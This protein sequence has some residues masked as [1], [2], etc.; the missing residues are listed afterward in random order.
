MGWSC[1]HK[2]IEIIYYFKNYI[3]MKKIFTI[4]VLTIVLLL[5]GKTIFAGPIGPTATAPSGSG[6]SGSPYQISSLEN[7]YWLSASNVVVPSPDQATRWAAYYEQTNNIDATATSG[8]NPNV[9]G[10]FYGFSPIGNATTQFTG[11]YDGQNHTISNLYINRPA[12]D[13]IGLFGWLYTSGG[14]S[15]LGLTNIDVKGQ[16]GV[17]GLVGYIQSATISNVYTTGTVVGNYLYTSAMFGGLIGYNGSTCTITNSY[18]TANVTGINYGGGGLVG[19]NFGTI[20]SCYATG[21]VGGE[22]S[23][24]GGLVGENGGNISNSFAKGNVNGNV[25]DVNGEYFG[26]LVGRSRNTNITDCYATGSVTGHDMVGGL[27]GYVLATG[28]SSTITNSYSF[29]SV[30]GSTNV[31]GLIGYNSNGTITDSYWDTQTSGTAT[32]S[33]GTGKTTAQMKTLATF[34]SW[35]F[36]AG[37][38]IW[39]IKVPASGYISYPYLQGITYDTPEASPVVNP[40]PGLEKLPY[41]GGTGTSGD[42]YHITDWEQLHNISLN[43]SSYFV[44]D[45]DLDASS[46][47][48][49]T[50]AS[51]TANSNAGWLPLA[52]FSGNFNGNNH[53]IDGL[54]INRTGSDNIGLFGYSTG[55]I[56]NVGLINVTVSGHYRVGGLVG[57]NYTPGSISNVYTSGSVTSVTGDCGGL[58]GINSYASITNAYSTASVIGTVGY[59]GGLVGTN[60]G[61]TINKSYSAGSVPVIVSCSGG[62]VG[63]VGA[64]GTTND[65]FW[66]TQT[67]GQAS[68]A[69]GTG[70]TTYQMK[71]QVTFTAGGWDFATGTGVWTLVEASSGYR[72][73]PYFQSFTYDTPGDAP[74]AVNPIPGLLPIPVV[75][76]FA[77]LGTTGPTPYQT[78]KEAFDAINTGTHK[79]D[80]TITINV[81]TTETESAVLYH[82]GYSPVMFIGSSYD[83]VTIYPTVTGLSISGDLAAPLIDLNG[84]DNVTIDGRVNATGSTADLVITNTSASLTAGTSTIRFINDASNNTVKYNTLKGSSLDSGGGAIF[85][86]TTTGTTGN[87]NNTIDH[88]NITC[89]ADANRPVNA[90]Y[91]EGVYSEGTAAEDNSGNNLSNNNFY[92]FMR[93]G[94][95]SNGILLFTN[96]TAWTISGNSFYETSTFVPTAE[97]AAYYFIYIEN[98]GYNY[99]VTNNYI[100]GTA[101]LCGGTAF[102]KSSSPQYNSIFGGIYLSTNAGTASSIQ[103]NTISNISWTN[104]GTASWRGILTDGTGDVNIGT[105]TANTI[106]ASTGNASIYFTTSTTGATFYGIYLANTG[107]TVVHD[108]IIGAITTSNVATNATNL[109]G[110][111]KTGA[112]TTSI[113]NNL[114]GSATTSNSLYASW[115]ALNNAQIVCGI[116]SLGSGSVTISDNTISKLT[117]GTTATNAARTGSVNGIVATDGT[118]T[119]SGNT[120]R[121]LSIANANNTSNHTASVSGIAL[122][123]T[124]AAAQ[125]ITGNTIYNLSNTYTSFTGNVIGLYYNGSTTASTVSKNFIHSLSMTSPTTAA[126]IYGIK[127]QNGTTIWSNNII[128]IGS[129]LLTNIYGIYE[130]GDVGNNN[131]LYYNTIYISGDVGSAVSKS[132]ALFSA[133]STNTRNFRNNIFDNQRFMGAKSPDALYSNYA[134]WFDYAVSTNLT[135]GNNDYYVSVMGSSALG[136]FNSAVV[137]SVPL[138]TGLD[139]NSKSVDPVFA[140]AGGTLAANYLPSETS[141]IA[142]TGTGVTTDYDETTR[143]TSFPSMGAHEYSIEASTPTTQAYA[144]VFSAVGTTRM[145]IGWTNGNGANRVVFVKEGTG[146]ITN[147]TDNTTYTASADWTSKGT[148]LGTSGYYCVY[149]GSSNT[150]DLTGLSHSTSYYVQVFEYNGPALGEKYNTTT[151]T[152]NPK[153][154]ATLTAYFSEGTNYYSSWSSMIAG[155][156][157]GSTVTLLSAYSCDAN[158]IITNSFTL[159]LNGFSISNTGS[160]TTEIADGKSFNLKN[161]SLTGTFNGLLSFAGSTSTLGLFSESVLGAGFTISA[162]STATGI[163]QIGDGTTTLSHTYTAGD[164]KFNNKISK[165]VIKNSSNLIMNPIL[166]TK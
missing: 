11:N 114:I 165:I 98:S 108:N 74:P 156:S 123:N 80:I 90:V 69:G 55:T 96:N 150:V 42:P 113:N 101:P 20:I 142:A 97:A 7:L 18:S 86:S 88:C 130:R 49:A 25:S 6:T 67:S 95:H 35:N 76:V 126:N 163:L 66:D 17:G 112:G 50:F 13:Y 89:S 43:L 127:I 34:S 160:Y 39:Q 121:D 15:N 19:W 70:K 44:L 78:L 81:S 2:K 71:T 109:Y 153:N 106:G 41:A 136:Y 56:S 137:N 158:V 103:G 52:T 79:G 92:N 99:S 166:G 110:I 73:Y 10:G 57:F 48:Y 9:S 134:A 59:C 147:P 3:L 116:M 120:V 58:V 135:L 60:W 45:N 151:A 118:N 85:F 162:T 8:W 40:I 164:A 82:S 125:T 22:G 54:N 94:S 23:C 65:S 87:D 128:S 77:T 27:V 115:T 131:S 91:S 161:T 149:N 145:T 117:N 159:N 124:T 100:G 24:R 28:G 63:L 75:E 148:Q 12:T 62:L 16:A 37:T 33:G 30:S 14:I 53:T 139:A 107:T 129:N 157:A 119:I 46:T 29:G 146:A 140:S 51:A 104:S 138:I 1:D 31:G 141:L 132:Y 47:G 4:L 154:Q 61:G 32:S 133:T 83:F 143:S 64:S 144:I 26:G 111:Y 68:S 84:A 72:S 5:G 21:S 155:V 36:T 93:T 38:G 102:T 122:N 105:T 152:D